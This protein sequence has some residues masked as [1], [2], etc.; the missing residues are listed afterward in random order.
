MRAG[1]GLILRLFLCRG[2][3]LGMQDLFPCRGS[4]RLPHGV[5]RLGAAGAR[6]GDVWSPCVS[7]AFRASGAG[8][9]RREGW[10]VQAWS[11]RL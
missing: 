3:F 10:A 8:R 11:R 4:G 2:M 6:F 9:S 1:L 5:V 7:Q